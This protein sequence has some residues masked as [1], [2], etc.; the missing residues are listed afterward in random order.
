[1]VVFNRVRIWFQKEIEQL[2]PLVRDAYQKIYKYQLERTSLY[3][4]QMREA[5][6]Q[7]TPILEVFIEHIPAYKSSYIKVLANQEQLAA[8][9]LILCFD[10]AMYEL[11]LYATLGKEIGKYAN[12][13]PWS[14]ELRALLNERQAIEPVSNSTSDEEL[15]L[16]SGKVASSGHA[17]GIAVVIMHKDELVNVRNGDI[18]VT[19]M[20]TP[21]FIEVAPL[22]AGLVTD[23]GGI[24]CH[25][26]IL[27][28][29]FNIPCIVGCRNATEVVKSGQKIRMD[30][31][32]GIV[33]GCGNV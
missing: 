6:V 21:D 11:H 24:V 2:K 19:T 7:I 12:E 26:A 28:R 30:A 17:E 3:E 29:E 8:S 14:K 33:M 18:L 13:A 22:I 10:R 32:S 15:F 5:I 20:T 27:A 9:D 4:L 25:A 16:A 31:I 1:M 23:R